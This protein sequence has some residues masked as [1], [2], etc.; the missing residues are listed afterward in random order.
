MPAR[1]RSPTP[2]RSPGRSATEAGRS[3]TPIVLVLDDYHVVTNPTIHSGIDQLLVE[4]PSILRLVIGTRHDPPLMLA[5]L[6]ADDALREIRFDDLQF[7]DAD[8]AALL[9]ET[10]RIGLTASEL[11]RLTERTEGWAVGVQLVG[12]S[13]RNQA[14]HGA[15]IDE[16]A[17]DDR[18]VADYLRDEVLARLPERVERFLVDT[19]ILDRLNAPLCQAVSGVEESQE[20]LEEL[21]R[22]NLFMIPL[23]HRRRW[24]RYHH[25]FAEWLRLQADDD[26]RERHRRAGEWLAAHGFPG[27][28][29]RHLVA[30][31]EADRAADVIDRAHWVLVGQGREET[32]RDWTRQLPAEVL[33]RRPRSDPERGVGC[34]QGRPLGRRTR[35]ARR[36]Q[37]DRR[38]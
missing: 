37:G 11:A 4:A 33:R 18:H 1:T 28:A 3:G 6:R 10:M 17:G 23:D 13:L 26:P 38:P 20:I 5:R 7:D 16:F 9:N 25:L 24:F 21:D 34:A 27:D 36:V 8:V 30:A 32:L 19:A 15:F 2:E 22:L 29:V 14:D 31:G 35:P 12:L